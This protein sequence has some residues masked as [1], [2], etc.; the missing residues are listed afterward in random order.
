MIQQQHLLAL[1]WNNDPKSFAQELEKSGFDARG[2][3]IYRR[4]LLA[5]AQRALSITFPTISQLLDS[6][7]NENLVQGFLKQCP[8]NQGD[9]AQWG[10]DFSHF[11]AANKIAH[12]YSYL[13]DC[14]ALDWHIHKALN[15]QDQTLDY[16]SLALLASAEPEDINITLNNNVAL[17]K[18]TSPISEIF[19][20]HHHPD[21]QQR[22]MAMEQAKVALNT[23]PKEHTV[24]VSRPEFQPKVTTLTDSEAEFMFCLKAKK[25][26]AESLD[27]VSHYD[28]F[29]FEEW[30]VAAIEQNL[31]LH[32]KENSL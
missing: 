24:M 7:V 17:I 27:T 25:S 2:I 20:A 18:T 13:P 11:I 4:N 5:N 9:W 14:A 23:K 22:K 6:D 8:P 28:N 26:L 19:D 31:I 12:E 15:G 16:T 10:D 30:L 29:S 32:F 1:I 21:Q 3:D